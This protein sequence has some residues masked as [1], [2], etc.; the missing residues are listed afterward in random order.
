MLELL[1][2]AKSKNVLQSLLQIDAKAQY[3]ANEM[4]S[5]IELPIHKTI[6]AALVEVTQPRKRKRGHG[7]MA[8][9]GWKAVQGFSHSHL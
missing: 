9:S 3:Q 8:P 6:T 4:K 1:A 2:I 7:S 5:A